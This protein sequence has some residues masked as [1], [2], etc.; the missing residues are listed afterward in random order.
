MKGIPLPWMN[1][2]ISEAMRDR[3][4]HHRKATKSNYLIIGK[5]IGGLEILL[6]VKENLPNQNIIVI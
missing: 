5:Y 2:K 3:D 4:Y 6:I 1:S